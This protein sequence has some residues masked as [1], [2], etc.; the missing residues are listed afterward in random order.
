MKYFDYLFNPA[1]RVI[2]VLLGILIGGGAALFTGWTMG[3][4]VGAVTVLVSAILYPT[5]AYFRDLPYIRIKRKLPQPFLFDA[6]VSITVK[7]GAVDGFFILTDKSM[8]F[9]A[10]NRETHSLELSREDVKAVRKGEN[11]S[12][13]IFLNDTQLIRVRTPACDD[14]LK[15]LADKG[16]C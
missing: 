11:F 7:N 6:R 9:L 13:H 14:L 10:I 3:A 12:L 5:V 1:V 2:S 16:W 8:Y 15:I 4:F